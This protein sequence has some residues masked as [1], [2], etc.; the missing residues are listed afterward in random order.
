MSESKRHAPKPV[1]PKPSS[2]RR[3]RPKG[4]TPKPPNKAATSVRRLLLTRQQTAEALGGISVS[5][6]IRLEKDGRLSKVRL[7]GL[8]GQVF[9]RA[10]E[11]EAL[12]LGEVSEAADA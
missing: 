12:A 9:N 2:R 3:G 7:R 11:V 1:P 5:S 10:D 4:F 8:T 6:V